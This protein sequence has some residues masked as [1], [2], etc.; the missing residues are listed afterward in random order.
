MNEEFE[1]KF[2]RMCWTFHIDADSSLASRDYREF[3]E[4]F[5]KLGLKHGK[6]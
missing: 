6:S 4:Q 2:R 3:A 1:N 5:Y